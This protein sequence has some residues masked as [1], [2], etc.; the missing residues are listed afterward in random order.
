[1]SQPA[2]IVGENFEIAGREF[3]RPVLLHANRNPICKCED[4]RIT[5]HVGLNFRDAE[6]TP[7]NGASNRVL[8]RELRRDLRIGA[9]IEW[10]ADKAVHERGNDNR[11]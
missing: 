4:C 11:D 7:F 6:L 3:A 1:M 2:A 9:G 10:S 5:Y 8:D